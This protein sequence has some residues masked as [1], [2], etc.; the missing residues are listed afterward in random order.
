[1]LY[2]SRRTNKKG[3]L[4]PRMQ[5]L[6]DNIDTEL[7][8]FFEHLNF[9]LSNEFIE[10]WKFIYSKQYSLIHLGKFHCRNSKWRRKPLLR[11]R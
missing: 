6:I 11:Q 9:V 5:L 10:K 2:N 8:D 1:M 7:I 3:K 4:M